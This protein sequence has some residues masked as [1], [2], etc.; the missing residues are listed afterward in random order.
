MAFLSLKAAP[1]SYTGQAMQPC[2]L[3]QL[4]TVS[5]PRAW[6]RTVRHCRTSVPA[7][8]GAARR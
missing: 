2:P 7:A 3:P 5:P 1:G 4:Q 6:G 8:L